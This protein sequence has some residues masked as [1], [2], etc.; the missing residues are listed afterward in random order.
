M[1]CPSPIPEHGSSSPAPARC[2][3]LGTGSWTGEGC[4]RKGGLAIHLSSVFPFHNPWVTQRGGLP[5]KVCHCQ[6]SRSMNWSRL[7]Q[8][9]GMERKWNVTTQACAWQPQQCNNQSKMI[10]ITLAGNYLF[11]YLLYFNENW[12]TPL[13][14]LTKKP[15][16]FSSK[17]LPYCFLFFVKSIWTDKLR[18]EQPHL[19]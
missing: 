12:T 8:S 17:L 2:A 15:V 5:W 19:T 10:N 3:G 16:A 4:A 13:N 1:R 7:I 14:L 18:I 11:I 9:K 6:H